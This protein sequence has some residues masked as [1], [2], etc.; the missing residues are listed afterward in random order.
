MTTARA[1]LGA[2]IGGSGLYSLAGG[3]FHE[4]QVETA[5]GAVTLYVGEGDSEGI[6]FLPRHG[7]GHATPPHRINYRANIKALALLG[8]RRILATA[9]VGSLNPRVPPG[10]LAL[11]DQFLDFTW[12][13]AHTYFDGGDSG[14]A[15]VDVTE[16][17]CPA[18]RAGLLR[19]AQERGLQIVERA[20][21]V[22]MEGPRFETAA[23]VRMLAAL[24]GDVV[25]M[26]GVPE[27]SLARELGICYASV[28]IPMNWGAG[29]MK[30]ELDL[31]QSTRY[32][33]E[34]TRAAVQICLDVLRAEEAALCTCTSS[35]FVLHPPANEGG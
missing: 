29:L 4:Q 23:E 14:V 35:L 31:S 33:E 25:G 15:H 7:A 17:Y 21:Y 20:T 9:A 22:C 16:P 18:L 2:I 5:Y 30:G 32:L 3:T 6:I 26:T 34:G 13:R 10:R 28:A 1:P 19:A 8:V 12:G 11:L 24:G 27:V